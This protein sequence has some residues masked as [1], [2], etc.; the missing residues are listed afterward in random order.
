[1]G[2][3]HAHLSSPAR[4]QSSFAI[5]QHTLEGETCAVFIVESQTSKESWVREIETVVQV[6]Q[7]QCQEADTA[8]MTSSSGSSGSTRQQHHQQMLQQQYHIGAGAGASAGGRNKNLKAVSVIP[9]QCSP[10][11]AAPI[12]AKGR[13]LNLHT[14]RNTNTKRVGGGGGGATSGSG[15]SHKP[16]D[17]GSALDLSIHSSMFSESSGKE[18]GSYV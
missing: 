15:H 5:E 1:M 9:L 13:Q 12:L 7:A 16:S 11:P 2:K 10:G 8:G 3:S 6:A 18:H 4:Y 14:D 17:D